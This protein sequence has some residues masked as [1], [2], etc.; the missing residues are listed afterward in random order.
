ML[1]ITTIAALVNLSGGEACRYSW[2]G[3][4][5]TSR[6]DV[7]RRHGAR[8]FLYNYQD[9]RCAD[10]G[11][12]ATEES[13]EFCH[14]VSRGLDALTSDQ[15]KGWTPGNL[16]LGHRACPTSYVR[17]VAERGNKAQ[18]ARGAVVL[19]EHIT[20]PDLVPGPDAWPTASD[21]RR[22]GKAL[23]GLA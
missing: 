1:L 11:E 10:C 21:M 3:V 13:L 17:G 6:F 23:R 2:R 7:N 8:A 22:D 18:Q 19:P 12:H 9:G 15:G 5:G 14:I 16:F 4:G 20:R